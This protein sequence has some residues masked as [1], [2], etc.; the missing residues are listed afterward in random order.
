MVID[1]YKEVTYFELINKLKEYRDYS[2]KSNAQIAVQLGFR[3]SQTLANALN[4]NEQNVK[5]STLTKI[6]Q[7]LELDGAIVWING[8]KHYYISTKIK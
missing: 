1:G 6:M 5:D 4:Q 8:E 2:K 7:H 3:A